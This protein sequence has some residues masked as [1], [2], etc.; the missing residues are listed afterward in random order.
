M[1][2]PQHEI[3][4]LFG[5]AVARV[6]GEKPHPDAS[7]NACGVI[8]K[9][10]QPSR[11]MLRHVLKCDRINAE[12]KVRWL[13]YDSQRRHQRAENLVTPPKPCRSTTSSSPPTSKRLFSTPKSASPRTS[14]RKKRRSS[15]LKSL[16]Q[17]QEENF[18][19]VAMGLSATGIPFRVIDDPHF[20]AIFDCELPSRRQIS[21]RLLDMLFQRELL[22]IIAIMRGATEWTLVTD[23]RSNVNGDSVINFVFVNTKLSPIF[24]KSIDTMAEVH[25]GRYIA[26]TI[27]T[28]IQ[29]V[30]VAVGRNVVTAVVSGNAANMK[31][32]WKLVRKERPGMVCTSCTAHGMNLLVKDIFR[33][34]F[35]KNVLE[36]LLLS[37]PTSSA[38]SERSWSIHGFIHT[39]LRNRLTPERVNK[40]V[41][42]YTNIA[43][44]SEVNHIMY[45]LFPDACDDSDFSDDSDCD[46]DG[47]ILAA[48]TVPAT[49]VT[50][51]IPNES[52]LRAE[53]VAAPRIMEE[54]DAFTTPVTQKSV[55]RVCQTK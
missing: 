20:Q 53:R 30:Q 49:S 33:L 41:F 29:E 5:V 42:V 13:E 31:K 50:Q 8:V 47:D 44:K 46:D 24:W 28:A 18:Q 43:R 39:K 52:E 4:G 35:F 21:G 22:R 45:Q 48:A 14:S 34:T 10:A 2:P 19:R 11:N 12:S 15:S 38:S 17:Q 26:D 27:L 1:A 54:A 3:W 9:N 32:A 7:C 6:C 55:Q 51:A 40:L 37:I 36:K 23:G 16:N 25:T